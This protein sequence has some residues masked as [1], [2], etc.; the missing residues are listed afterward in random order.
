MRRG[1]PR[2]ATVLVLAGFNSFAYAESL[3]D[4]ASKMVQPKDW[5]PAEIKTVVTPIAQSQDCTKVSEQ[6]P[7]SALASYNPNAGV[8][9]PGSLIQ[10]VGANGSSSKSARA[11]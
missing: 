1:D 8:L 9:W 4:Y 6:E 5:S 7:S 3:D 10:W 2:F 11:G